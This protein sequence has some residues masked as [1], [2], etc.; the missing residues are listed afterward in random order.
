MNMSFYNY[1]GI[2]IFYKMVGCSN[3]CIVLLHGLGSEHKIFLPIMEYKELSKQ[4]LLFIDLIGF[5]NS[6]K[7]LEFDY[8]MQGQA[9]ACMALITHLGIENPNLIAHSMGGVVAQLIAEGIRINSFVNCEG[10][11]TIDDCKL[12]AKIYEQGLDLFSRRGFNLLKRKYQDS[13]YYY[14][15]CST[16][17]NAIYTSS[18]ELIKSCKNDNIQERFIK[19]ECKMMYIIGE[20]NLGRRK[21]EGYLKDTGVITRY[22]KDSGHNM[23]EENANDF[24]KTVIEFY[25]DKIC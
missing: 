23:V 10:N 2:N 8:S 13:P 18:T 14:S 1:K 25:M 11:L 19:N 7:S 15:L 24:Y 5:G 6:D 17:A 3:E 4:R 21:S 12:S 16:N 20:K 22:I 9:D